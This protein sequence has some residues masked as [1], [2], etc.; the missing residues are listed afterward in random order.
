MAQRF[1]IVD[2]DP[3]HN[4]ICGYA[5]KRAFNRAFKNFDVRSFQF[6]AEALKFI[7]S[8]Y[9]DTTVQTPTTLFLDINMPEINGWDFLN[10]FAEMDEHIQKQFI[11]Y[12]LSS[13]IDPADKAKAKS[14]VHIRD[15]LS[16]PLLTSDVERLTELN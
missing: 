3:T 8:E 12:V 15:F 7:A 2:D 1:I 10:A 6:P 5:I 11:I 14:N 16:K 4:M 9:N 13:S